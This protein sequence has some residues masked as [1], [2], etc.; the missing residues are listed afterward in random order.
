MTTGLI[1]LEGQPTV[2]VEDSD[3]PVPFRQRRYFY[4]LS[5]V[6]EPDCRLTYDIKSD[7]LTLYLPSYDLRH[8]IY[9][10][11]GLTPED[12]LQKYVKNIPSAF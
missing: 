9:N 3:Q 11:Q 12:A 5:G 2:L 6:D 10:G 8:V 1:Y 7:T 4:Y